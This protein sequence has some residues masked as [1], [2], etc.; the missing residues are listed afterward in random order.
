MPVTSDSYEAKVIDYV[1]AMVA[2]SATFQTLTGAANAAA[3]RAFVIETE[4]GSAQAKP[5]ALVHSEQFADERLAHGVY[6]HRGEVI[7]VIHTTNTGSDSAPEVH[8][9]LRNTA[10]SIKAEMLALVGTTGYLSNCTID[11]DGPV[12]KDETGADAG[13]AQIL[14]TLK[15]SAP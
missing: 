3:A 5:Y 10:G 9:R 12:R 8:R 7:V 2:A 11:V 13:T 6:G 14:L 4:K 15:W 1:A